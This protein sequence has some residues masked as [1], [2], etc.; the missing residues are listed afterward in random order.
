VNVEDEEVLEG[1]ST[2][3]VLIK[4]RGEI[5]EKRGHAGRSAWDV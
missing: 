4:D 2:L 1:K 5:G 3:A